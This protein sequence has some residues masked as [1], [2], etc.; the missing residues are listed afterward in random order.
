MARRSSEFKSSAF[1][2]S[3]ILGKED[4]GK[5]H[6]EWTNFAPRWSPI[7]LKPNYTLREALTW[8]NAHSETKRY[9]LVASRNSMKS[10]WARI[11]ALCLTITCP[12][13]PILIVSET[14][15]LSRKAMSE[16]RGY[17]ELSP[18]N[19]T[20]FQQYFGEFTVS[21]EGSSLDLREPARPSRLAAGRLRKSA[22]WRARTL[23][24][25]S[26]YASSMTPF[27]VITEHPTM[28][29]VP[30]RSRSTAPL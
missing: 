3:K 7:G 18:N 28:N 8:L 12:D 29:N 13:A 30:P 11:F 19:P 16:F 5:V 14:N 4:F 23:G 6:E 15:K 22:R 2:L 9:L 10:T 1:E 27:P 21:S 25:D 24:R 20:L 26:G 17:L